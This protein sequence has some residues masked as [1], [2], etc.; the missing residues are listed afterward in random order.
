MRFKT[1]ALCA[2]LHLASWGGCAGGEDEPTTGVTVDIPFEK[3]ADP[4]VCQDD[5]VTAIVDVHEHIVGQEGLAALQATMAAAGVDRTVAFPMLPDRYEDSVLLIEAADELDGSLIPFPAI[6]VRDPIAVAFLETSIHAGG[7]GLKLF[8]GHGDVHG[9]TPLDSPLAEPVYEYL[10]STD[11]PLLM[12]VNG[13]LYADE[14]ERVLDAHPDLVVICPHLCLFSHRPGLLARLLDEH[15]NLSVDLSFGTPPA[16]RMAFQNISDN[17]EVWRRF[18]RVYV[19]RIAFGSDT[20]FVSDKTAERD[21]AFVQ[22]YLGL[23]RDSTFEYETFV[24]NGLAADACT[25]K[26]LLQHNAERFVAG[27]PPERAP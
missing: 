8:S 7:A 20:V 4:P 15:P 23:V 12:H 18:V 22:A 21:L 14:L 1:L 17:I 10:E 13:P 16:A 26:H 3:D 2:A 6:D 5:E 19:D 9:E 27:L 24:F 25:Q 11:T